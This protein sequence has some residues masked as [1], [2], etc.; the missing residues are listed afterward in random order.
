M[1]VNITHHLG[2]TEVSENVEKVVALEFSFVDALNELG[3]NVAGIADDNDRENLVASLKGDLSDYTSVGTRLEPDVS[4]IS[5]LKPDL[6]IADS[7]RHK[8]IIHDLEAVA[9]TIAL[10]SFEGNYQDQIEAFQVIGKATSNEDKANERLQQ[11]KDKMKEYEDDVKVDKTASTIAAVVTDNKIVAHS[12]KSYVGQILQTLGF[13]LEL[14]KEQ[15]A[16]Y[17]EYMSS[18]YLEIEATDLAELNPGRLIFMADSENDENV[19]S[20]QSSAHYDKLDAPKTGRVHVVSRNE[21]AKFRG[22]SGAEKVA[23]DLADFKE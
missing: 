18:E 1:T 19:K 10:K 22:L 11:H 6:I 4:A 9:P 5:D 21:W 2:E 17:S 13:N 3:V 15:E 7:D 16:K 8:D 23:H 20:L 12:V 14:T